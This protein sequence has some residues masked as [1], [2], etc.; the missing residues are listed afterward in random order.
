MFL[1]DITCFNDLR[2]LVF[3]GSRQRVIEG[4]NINALFRTARLTR[5]RFPLGVKFC[6]GSDVT[7]CRCHLRSNQKIL[8]ICETTLQL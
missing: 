5:W 4:P 6:L 7:H 1:F 8:R 3:S 2:S